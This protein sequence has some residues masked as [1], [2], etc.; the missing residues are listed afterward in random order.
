MY[1]ISF[2]KFKNGYP[3]ETDVS[4]TRLNLETGEVEIV[5]P[6]KCF[7][8]DEGRLEC[9]K[10]NDVS[11]STDL[12]PGDQFPLAKT[13]LRR[14]FR[15]RYELKRLNDEYFPAQYSYTFDQDK[16]GVV[17]LPGNPNTDI[18]EDNSEPNV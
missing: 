12:R 17:R 1:S 14:D 16:P 4:N 8:A 18:S 9:F 13:D 11:V 5:Q 3:S 6:I 2:V 7:D 10:L 15:R